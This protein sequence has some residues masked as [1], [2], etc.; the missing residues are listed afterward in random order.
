VVLVIQ[1][2]KVPKEMMEILE[3]VAMAEMVVL[4]E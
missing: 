4:V 1:E 2:I 3:R